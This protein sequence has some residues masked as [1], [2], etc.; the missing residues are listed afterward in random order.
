MLFFGKRRMKQYNN[1][2]WSAL[3][4]LVSESKIA[5]D[6][7][8]GSKIFRLYMSG[9]DEENEKDLISF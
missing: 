7:P 2:F 3:E 9:N 1:G 5:I 4:K 6:R 8:K